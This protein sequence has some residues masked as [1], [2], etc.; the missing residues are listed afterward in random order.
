MGVCH[1]CDSDPAENHIRTDNSDDTVVE[2]AYPLLKKKKPIPAT[3]K[4]SSK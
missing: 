1:C 2:N 4:N 3:S